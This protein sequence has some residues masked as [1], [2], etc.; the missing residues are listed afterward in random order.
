MPVPAPVEELAAESLRRRWLGATPAAAALTY[1]VAPPP[2]RRAPPWSPARW[3]RA[4]RRAAS[5]AVALVTAA[6]SLRRRRPGPRRRSPLRVAVLASLLALG[7]LAVAAAW[8]TALPPSRDARGVAV[9]PADPARTRA[10]A[11]EPPTAPAAAA[12]AEPAPPVL[13]ASLDLRLLCDA[14]APPIATGVDAASIEILARGLG[15]CDGWVLVQAGHVV[16]W[17]QLAPPGTSD[18][19][20]PEPLP[21]ANAIP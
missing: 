20:A 2:P 14:S 15:R 21:T 9:A 6:R 11:T 17:V 3:R 16:S 5:A 18:T 19:T 1:V 7:L 8:R 13:P 10:A 12:I 4:L